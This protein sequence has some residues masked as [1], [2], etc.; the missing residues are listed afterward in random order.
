MGKPVITAPTVG[1]RHI[2]SDGDG[3]VFVPFSDPAAMADAIEAL[4]GDAPR[5]ASLGAR[6]TEIYR[7]RFS[8][9]AGARN[10]GDALVALRAAGRR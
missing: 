5:R 1:A 3:A 7:E 4:V 2:F 8:L 9:D 10:L 6:A